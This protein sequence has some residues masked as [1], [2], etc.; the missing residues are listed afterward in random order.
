MI[1]NQTKEELINRILKE[2]DIKKSQTYKMTSI[3]PVKSKT[4][5]EMNGYIHQ[6]DE[7]EFDGQLIEG[8]RLT[9]NKDSIKAQNCKFKNLQFRECVCKDAIFINCDFEDFEIITSDLE[10]IIFIACDFKRFNVKGSV[11]SKVNLKGMKLVRCTF[12]SSCDIKNANLNDTQWLDT[13]INSIDIDTNPRSANCCTINGMIGDDLRD[14]SN[15]NDD[16]S[17]EI[18]NVDIKSL[19]KEVISDKEYR[20]EII[21]I[22]LFVNTD[23]CNCKFMNCTFIDEI[24][25]NNDL[26][27]YEMRSGFVNSIF[28]SCVFSCMMKGIRFD[29]CS[30]IISELNGNFISCLFIS[31]KFTKCSLTPQTMMNYSMFV[32]CYFEETDLDILKVHE[33]RESRGD[34]GVVICEQVE[35][36]QNIVDLEN[37]IHDLQ[38]E[39]EAAITESNNHIEELNKVRK[40]LNEIGDELFQKNEVIES[41][42]AEKQKLELQIEEYEKGKLEMDK[43]ME[44]KD[45]EIKELRDNLEAVSKEKNDY[46]ER[47]TELQNTI[48]ILQ[49]KA[50]D[51]DSSQEQI[52]T[53]TQEKK[54]LEENIIELQNTI[55]LLQEQ[56]RNTDGTS[57]INNEELV[58]D[59]VE[60]IKE[61][62]GIDLVKE[63]PVDEDATVQFL[64]TL[65]EDERLNIFSKAAAL[66]MQNAM[67]GNK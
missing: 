33:L 49:V 66:R 57:S 23:F 39:K 31:T 43:A 51:G 55:E 45:E 9:K 21:D 30:F 27:N 8:A 22:S 35:R 7:L 52:E 48:E 15:I 50:K 54:K 61:K 5:D 63:K 10:N 47:I 40:A 6:T 2:K 38:E 53:L 4:N 14:K 24:F 17:T 36:V 42:E 3:E 59:I 37:H 41:A 32:N 60:L 26:Y 44:M 12:D 18:K 67:M 64:A 46:E 1:D 58:M 65:S 62:T 28:E 29:N 16:I 25:E 13:D 56:L 34:V 20:D 11:T 19:E